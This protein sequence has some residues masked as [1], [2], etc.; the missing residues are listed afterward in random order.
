MSTVCSTSITN[1]LKSCTENDLRAF[2]Y[3]ALV[4]RNTVLTTSVEDLADKD[5][6]TDLIQSGDLIPLP[7]ILT[8]EKS[9]TDAVYQEFGLGKSVKVKD[10]VRKETDHVL[11]PHC[12]HKALRSLNSGK[13]DLIMWDEN[14]NSPIRMVASDDYRGLPVDVEVGLMNF[15][16][17]SDA[18][19]TPIFINFEDSALF[20][21]EVIIVKNTW[22]GRDVIDAALIDVTLATVGT[23]TASLLVVSVNELCGYDSGGAIEYPVTG[24]VLGDFSI[25][26][27]AGAAQTSTGLTDNADG[28]FNLAFDA[29]LE[30]GNVTLKTPASMTTTGYKASNTLTFTI[31]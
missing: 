28:T 30:S 3:K 14:R 31:T 8:I 4:K 16:D 20:D 2:K 6:Y 17:G 9:N 29:D 1:W 19:Y 22:S 5:T 13:W 12:S 25:K 7:E 23:P 10:T 18:A 11:I 27:T 24:L 26:T 21:D 15:S